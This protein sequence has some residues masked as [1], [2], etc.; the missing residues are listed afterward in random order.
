MLLVLL[1]GAYWA[2][3]GS[4]V[5]TPDKPESYPTSYNIE[6]ISNNNLDVGVSD[7]SSKLISIKTEDLHGSLSQEQLNQLNELQVSDFTVVT[8]EELNDLLPKWETTDV[9]VSSPPVIANPVNWPHNS[10]A[11]FNSIFESNLFAGY[12]F[13][14]CQYGWYVNGASEQNPMDAIGVSYNYLSRLDGNNEY[15]EDPNLESGSRLPQDIV[16]YYFPHSTQFRYVDFAYEDVVPSTADGYEG[17]VTLTWTRI[18]ESVPVG[19][20]LVWENTV[21]EV[22]Q[23]SGQTGYTH[24]TNWE[25]RGY[26]NAFRMVENTLDDRIVPLHRFYNTFKAVHFFTISD[27][28]V[29]IIQDTLPEYVYEGIVSKVYDEPTGDADVIPIYRFYNP[30][31]K[32]HFFTS[33]RSQRD[34]VLSDFPVFIYEGIAFYA[35]NSFAT[36]RRPVYRYY[37]R[38]TQVHFYTDNVRSRNTLDTDP[39]FS[40]FLYEGISH[41]YPI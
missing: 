28:Q 34:R 33:S 32:A 5:E 38:D 7:I 12:R 37:N 40:N 3:Q 30:E 17:L 19:A 15:F 4:S 22:Q 11:Y 18:K 6:E 13:V 16:D 20:T 27:R 21:C 26:A 29:S 24:V 41:Y 39:R 9:S 10:V 25:T 14:G 8:Q 31:T 1:L 2:W 36:S 23:P 35:N